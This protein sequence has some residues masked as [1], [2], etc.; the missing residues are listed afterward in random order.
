MR[1]EIDDNYSSLSCADAIVPAPPTDITCT[2][3]NAVTTVT[4]TN[5]ELYDNII[6]MRDGGTIEEE[7]SGDASSYTDSNPGPGPHRW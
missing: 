7:I 1:A 5:G 4:W 3:D 6:I 2:V